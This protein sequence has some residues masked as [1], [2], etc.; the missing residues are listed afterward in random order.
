MKIKRI[1]KLLNIFIS[2]RWLV[3][4]R[5]SVIQSAQNLREIKILGHYG[6]VQNNHTRAKK[7][8]L[9]KITPRAGHWILDIDYWILKI[10]VWQ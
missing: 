8:H 3:F 9:P 10:T 5:K 1:A 4:L 7:I 2:C 6:C